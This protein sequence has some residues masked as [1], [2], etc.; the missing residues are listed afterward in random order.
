MTTGRLRVMW[1]RLQILNSRTRYGAVSKVLH[2][3]IAA[4]MIGLVWL[5]WWMVGLD[6]YDSLYSPAFLLHQSFGMTVFG[7]A[8]I[9]VLWKRFSRSPSLQPEIPAWQRLA[10]SVMHGLLLLMMILLPVSGFIL[11]T[12]AGSGVDL[13]GLWTVPAVMSVSESVRNLADAA[14][15]WASY[16]LLFLVAVHAGA[17]I[18]HQWIDGHGTLR[19]ML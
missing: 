4:L 3:S 7:L 2:W 18:K 14:H 5:G 12:S 11:T 10:A 13:F 6:Y 1:N 15:Y 9:L 8:V 16:G 17:A 19:R